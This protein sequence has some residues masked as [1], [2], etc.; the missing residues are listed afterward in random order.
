MKL[1]TQF[2]IGVGLGLLAIGT[3]AFVSM[4][5]NEGDSVVQ[6]EETQSAILRVESEKSKSDEDST[7]IEQQ[8]T[9]PS[10]KVL[11]PSVDVI[12][13]DDGYN[14][15]LNFADGT[16]RLSKFEPTYEAWQKTTSSAATNGHLGRT[17]YNQ[18]SF[19]EIRW[20]SD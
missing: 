1:S 18:K 8:T 3:G 15:V 16:R 11:A 4:M 2:A 5:I 7:D 9:V 19:K 17:D 10:T 12:E 6:K 13:K 14:I 20:G